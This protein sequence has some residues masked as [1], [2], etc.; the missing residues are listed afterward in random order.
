MVSKEFLDR[1]VTLQQSVNQAL[2]TFNLPDHPSS[3][4]EPVKYSLESRGK[5]LRPILLIMLGSLFDCEKEKALHAGL[6]VEILH[7]FTLVHDDIM[8]EDNF[9]RGKP[10]VHKK[11]NVNTAILAGDGL[12]AA[13]Y[14][15]LMLTCS[16][17]L[18]TIG[19]IFSDGI[20]TICEGQSLDKDFEKIS[21]VSISQYLEMIGK[22][23]AT[24]FKVCA[25]IGLL[26]GKLS[27]HAVKEILED[28][29]QFAYKMGL[30]FQ[31]QDDLLDFTGN[32]KKLGKDLWSDFCSGKKT[33]PLLMA[34]GHADET[35]RSVIFTLLGKGSIS[36]NEIRKIEEIFLKYDI[37]DITENK[38]SAYM[39]EAM[40]HLKNITAVDT[41]LLQEFIKYVLKREH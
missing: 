39:N 7:T 27:D 9:R 38:V 30:A 12:I 32:Q 6:A 36:E 11:W 37:F 35:D 16:P 10:T 17:R 13:A 31:L 15:E 26:L 34:L 14:R 21:D 23:T 20:I 5:R 4:Y 40:T 33:Y 22:K 41:F 2:A 24:L 18:S 3:L 8:D 29:R 28:I 25:E 19:K 1:A